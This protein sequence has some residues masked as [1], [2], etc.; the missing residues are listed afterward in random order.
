MRLLSLPMVAWGFALALTACGDSDEIS[1]KIYPAVL[2]ADPGAEPAQGWRR[3][4]FGGSQRSG[5][6]MYHVAAEPLVTE[7]GFIALKAASLADGSK[8]VAVRLNAYSQKKIGEF[9]GDPANHKSF[10]AVE[11]DGQWVD[12]HPVLT[13]VR[14]RMMLHGFTEEQ[15]QRLHRN[16]ANR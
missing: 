5:A 8:A 9:T 7:Y 1:V 3:A 14:D 10:L 15:A 12:F 4:E 11:I 2:A 6:G 13:R 16:V